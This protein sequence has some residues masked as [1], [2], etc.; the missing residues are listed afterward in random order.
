MR[1]AGS[2]GVSA[3]TVLCLLCPAA[4]A[5][6]LG[7]HTSS[8]PVR[9]RGF[10]LAAVRGG[11]QN[12]APRACGAPIR[13]TRQPSFLQWRWRTRASLPLMSR[14]RV[15]PPG[16]ATGRRREAERQR[17]TGHCHAEQGWKLTDRAQG[18]AGPA[19]VLGSTSTGALAECYL[20]ASDDDC[21]SPGRRRRGQRARA[22]LPP[23]T[24]SSWIVLCAARTPL[25]I[26][27][28]QAAR[29][30]ICR[31]VYR[32]RQCQ[33]LRSGDGSA[34]D[35][36]EAGRPAGGACRADDSRCR[37]TGSHAPSTSPA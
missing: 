27:S 23:H 18:A 31:F 34:R 5:G 33:R 17:G 30:S 1:T 6:S 11:V 8:A 35:N 32:R 14:Q 37:A 26:Q 12:A 9:L 15:P 16:T 29:Y 22:S 19:R 7:V 24:H 20:A 4:S 36:G 2:V 21:P 3:E 28:I 25:Q 10:Q 13:R